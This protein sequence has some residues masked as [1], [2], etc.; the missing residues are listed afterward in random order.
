[1]IRNPNEP[2]GEK[3]KFRPADQKKN[4]VRYRVRMGIVIFVPLLASSI[5]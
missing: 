4:D 5:L 1:M 3:I 2:K